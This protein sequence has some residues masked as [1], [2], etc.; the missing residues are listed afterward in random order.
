MHLLLNLAEDPMIEVK[1]VR[2]GM[3]QFLVFLVDRNMSTA[4][5]SP[6]LPILALNFLKKLSVYKENKDSLIHVR[7]MILLLYHLALTFFKPVCGGVG[8]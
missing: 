7:I 6:E 3:I 2:R 8:T 4:S 1:M 5:T